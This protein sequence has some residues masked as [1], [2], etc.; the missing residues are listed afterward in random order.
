M[1]RAVFEFPPDTMAL[2]DRLGAS[3]NLKPP[4]VISKALGLLELWEAAN[5]SKPPRLIVE[6][7]AAGGAGE[8]FVIDINP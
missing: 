3:L 6:R 7:P 2:I 8:E 1:E 5:K 4:E